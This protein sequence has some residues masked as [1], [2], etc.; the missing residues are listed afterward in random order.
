MYVL[1]RIVAECDKEM[2]LQNLEEATSFT[3]KPTPVEEAP[4]V[5]FINY[6]TVN[7]NTFPFIEDCPL[8]SW[9]DNE[10]TFLF[11]EDCP[12]IAG[13]ILVLDCSLLE[14][15][16]KTTYHFSISPDH[17]SGDDSK[18]KLI[19]SHIVPQTDLDWWGCLRSPVDNKAFSRVLCSKS[20]PDLWY[21]SN[22]NTIYRP[23]NGRFSA[24]H[25]LTKPYKLHL[26][27]SNRLLPYLK[28]TKIMPSLE[29]LC[30]VRILHTYSDRPQHIHPISWKMATDYIPTI[31]LTKWIMTDQEHKYYKDKLEFFSKRFILEINNETPS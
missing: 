18:F 25:V 4:K 15:C 10:G 22:T 17:L 11:M 9:K 27:I 31:R 19:I 23:I 29:S 6:W 26:L 20:S 30:A 14:V 16:E 13:R 12:L 1:Y 24:L 8:I 28:I 5:N 3:I 7:E 2:V 21:S